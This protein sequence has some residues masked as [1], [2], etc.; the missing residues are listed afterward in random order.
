MSWTANDGVVCDA[1]TIR[2]L[3]KRVMD[4]GKMTKPAAC[5]FVAG[6]FP[7]KTGWDVYGKIE[8]WTL[9]GYKPNDK[10]L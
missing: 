4:D 7:N 6:M 8:G 1:D 3:V 5:A 10:D 2:K 9:A